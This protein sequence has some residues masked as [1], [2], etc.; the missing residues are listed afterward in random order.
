MTK[1]VDEIAVVALRAGED[2]F[3]LLLSTNCRAELWSSE[4]ACDIGDRKNILAEW[5]LSAEDYDQMVECEFADR[6]E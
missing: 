1:L 6:V 2:A 3:L 5:Q 4:D